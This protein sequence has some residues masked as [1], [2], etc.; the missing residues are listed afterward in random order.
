M[1]LSEFLNTLS[2][3]GDAFATSHGNTLCPAQI[4]HQILNILLEHRQDSHSY[5]QVTLH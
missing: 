3:F 4:H 5:N 2:L 1:N